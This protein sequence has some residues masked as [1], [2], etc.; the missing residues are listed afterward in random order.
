[1]FRFLIVS[2]FA[3]FP[4][5]G[6]QVFIEPGQTQE[7]VDSW[8]SSMEECGMR[9][10]RIRMYEAYMHAPDGGWDFSLF[11]NAFDSA[12]EHGI[13]VW[14]TLFPTAEKTDIGGWKFPYD[15]EQEQSFFCFVDSLI[16]HYKDHPA[17]KGWVL[18][19][20]PG[21]MRLPETPFMSESRRQ[22]DI[23]HPTPEFVGNGY[24]NLFP[25]VDG[26]FLLDL[27]TS[28]LNK[29]ASRIRSIDAVHDL[30]VNPHAV[31]MNYSQYDFPAYRDFLTS[32]GGSAHPSWHFGFFNRDEFT[33]AMLAQ[34]EILRS[35]AGE[36][37]WF[38]TEIQGGNNT[39]SGGRPICPTPE[40]I[41]QWLWAVI[42]CEGKGGIFWML[43]PRS[44]GKEA[45]EWAL[46][47]FQGKPSVR[48]KAAGEVASVLNSHESIFSS[49]KERPS[50]IDILYFRESE[51][52]EANMARKEDRSEGRLR[53]AAMK[54]VLAC[55]TALTQRG[56]NV[57]IKEFHEY[58]F[59][60]D[61]YMGRTLIL[62]QQIALPDDCLPEL[63]R[64]VRLGGTVIA[65]GL[66][67]FFNEDILCTMATDFTFKELFG[68]EVSEFIHVGE[69]FSINVGGKKLDAHLWRGQFADSG[70][71]VNIH[72]LGKGKVVWIPTCIGLGA[73]TSRNFKPLSDFLAGY[74]D[75]LPGTVSF[76]GFR[77][78][79][80]LRTLDSPDGVVVICMNKS[81]KSHRI[82]LRNLRGEPDVLFS[83]KSGMSSGMLKVDSE[84]T[85]VLY[86][87]NN[88]S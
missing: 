22:W 26:R 65:E 37:P 12:S 38:M 68:A 78:G 1:M 14:A 88:N 16:C 72:S 33:L 28:F 6:A 83:D 8:F 23:S 76:D 86:Y 80:M 67:A 73:W 60:L 81:G 77:E 56:L 49:L 20:E 64:F 85:I 52:A 43:N 58:D 29:I 11:D 59:S 71:N 15:T 18:I 66:T 4:G 87:P 63:E 13:G 25:P 69:L 7:Q 17:L 3:I 27:N 84:G 39:Y 36:L 70:E 9:S 19:N 62:T 31:F 74:S 41:R 46:L 51:W 61:D 10:C 55:F 35:G 24:P 50:G 34:S 40:E 53:G 57:G 30:H 75:V 45:G 21:L 2:L 47:D 5:I 79:L 48:M 82:R 42:G 54:S 32:L 44:G